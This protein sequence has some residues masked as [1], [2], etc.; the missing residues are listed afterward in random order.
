MRLFPT[1]ITSIILIVLIIPFTIRNTQAEEVVCFH[2]TTGFCI[3]GRI[4]DF[5]EQHGGVNVFGY[6]ITP[7]QSEMVAGQ[8]L[9]VQ[10]FERY[11]LELH[12]ENAAPYD[13]LMGHLGTELLQQ[14]SPPIQAF[15]LETPAAEDCRLFA[16]T[17]F[18]VCG[19]ILAAWQSNGIELDGILGISESESL[20]L[21]GF[22]VSNL[23]TETLSDGKQ[24]QVQWFER[25]RFEIHPENNPPYHVL[26]GL[27][28][29]ET[30]ATVGNTLGEHPEQAL[31][32]YNP[33]LIR[34]PPTA[35]YA[36]SPTRT[37]T[38]TPR[39]TQSVP[40]WMPTTPKPKSKPKPKH[41]DHSTQQ[42][43]DPPTATFTPTTETPIVVRHVTFVPNNPP[44]PSN[45][46]TL[47][48][49]TIPPAG[50]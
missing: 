19:D 7:Q 36:P 21:Y 5:W 49:A 3:E 16:E 17:G 12:P 34:T 50:K 26:P 29:N 14:Q 32:N 28:G 20:A 10:W 22:P 37:R 30:L 27:L 2:E 4:R 1:I 13:V 45:T 9:E 41:Q 23:R 33:T 18:H 38:P 39:S 15:T 46:P 31:P 44:T 47:E 43:V 25:V 42:P 35:T 40:N 24:Y 8:N 48:M 6:P 11:R